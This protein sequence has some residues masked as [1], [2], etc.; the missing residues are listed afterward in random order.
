MKWSIPTTAVNLKREE[1]LTLLFTILETLRSWIYS[2][3]SLCT[4]GKHKSSKKFN[5]SRLETGEVDNVYILKPR[6]LNEMSSRCFGTFITQHA[7][8]LDHFVFNRIPNDNHYNVLHYVL[9]SLS[10]LLCSPLGYFLKL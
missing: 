5:C 2:V 6:A 3:G 8:K 10:H 4:E 1:I 9:Y 7:L